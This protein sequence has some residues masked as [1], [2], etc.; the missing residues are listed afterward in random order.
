MNFQKKFHAGLTKEKRK[1]YYVKAEDLIAE[2]R[3]YKESKAKSPDGKGKISEELGIMIMKIC[4]RFS[5][6][7]RFFGYTYRDEFVADAVARCITHSIDKINLDHPKCNPFSYFTQTAYNVFRQKIKSEKK[8]QKIR[9]ELRNNIYDEFERVYGLHKTSNGNE[10]SDDG[11]DDEY[12]KSFYNDY[13]ENRKD[14][15]D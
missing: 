9:E 8:Q 14:K 13:Y 1:E 6:H 4:T 2:L 12:N 7:P 10:D 11:L 15:E 3:K 5:M